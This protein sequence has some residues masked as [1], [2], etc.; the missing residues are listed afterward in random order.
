MADYI[1]GDSNGQFDGLTAITPTT[2]LNS[3][4]RLS[5]KGIQVL[6][7]ERGKSPTWRELINDK[8]IIYEALQPG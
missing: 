3:I 4:I 1:L 2:D 5:K 7:F 8:H 6:L